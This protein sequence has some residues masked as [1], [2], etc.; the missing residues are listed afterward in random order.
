[1]IEDS[2]NSLTTIEYVEGKLVEANEYSD[3]N[4][5]KNKAYIDA[6]E[7]RVEYL[8]GHSMIYVEDETQ[9]YEKIVPTKAYTT[10][11]LKEVGGNTY[12]KLGENL[13]NPSEAYHSDTKVTVNPT[14]GITFTIPASMKGQLEHLYLSLPSEKGAYK[15]NISILHRET[16]NISYQP[17]V[18][19]YVVENDLELNFYTNPSSTDTYEDVVINAW[20][21]LV[22]DETKTSDIYEVTEDPTL[23]FKRYGNV[24]EIAKT[25]RVESYDSTLIP[26]PY[27]F[28]VQGTSFF[29]GVTYTENA[30]GNV[31]LKGTPTANGGVDL[32]VDD[33][34]LNSNP[35]LKKTETIKVI[36]PCSLTLSAIILGK[37]NPSIL[38]R[39]R[40]VNNT[41]VS[42]LGYNG[43]ASNSGILEKGE[44]VA[45]VA[46]YVTS[47]VEY[48]CTVYPVLNYGRDPAP[49]KAYSSNP[50]NTLN[51]PES[52][53]NDPD[54]GLRINVDYRNYIELT[55]NKVIYHKKVFEFTYTSKGGNEL[56][57]HAIPDQTA[58]MRF[59]FTTTDYP[60]M[61][62]RK[63][64]STL[65]ETITMS[66]CDRL[67]YCA[68]TEDKIGY[69]FDVGTGKSAY[70]KSPYTTAEETAAWLDGTRWVLA[71]ETPE[72]IDITE[73]FKACNPNF[74]DILGKIHTGE[75]FVEGGGTV[76]FCNGAK[77]AVDSVIQ[78]GV[79]G[80][81]CYDDRKR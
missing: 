17:S 74:G 4:A 56:R 46:I 7:R 2:K 29:Q 73:D 16:S 28:T 75:I 3:D 27:N 81:Y 9:A 33:Y 65:A 23:P 15:Y 48:D 64:I 70:V 13:I 39:K 41:D 68:Y 45:R 37:G 63:T 54:Y 35:Y 30:D 79:R 22:K 11:M 50:I 76:R 61:K 36:T 31:T 44:G 59:Y 69:Y 14:G 38:A 67:T 55:E 40:D 21:M 8:E 34:R 26:T 1:M 42:W 6:L 72:E 18:E 32:G 20:I 43:T 78:Y 49:F 53:L 24:F 19:V 25:D 57:L 60:E 12:R 71:L 58:T 51:L 10:A 52:V 5:L 80:V 47:G 77:S 62:K 66:I